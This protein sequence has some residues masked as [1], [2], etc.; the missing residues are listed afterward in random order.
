M[1]L[2]QNSGGGP[3]RVI[4]KHCVNGKKIGTGRKRFA[5]R[6]DPLT[7]VIQKTGFIVFS[8]DVRTPSNV[9]HAVH[10]SEPTTYI[11]I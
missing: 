8:S 3:L 10:A 6:G 5:T 9:D 2:V 11:N 7:E 4:L 1:V